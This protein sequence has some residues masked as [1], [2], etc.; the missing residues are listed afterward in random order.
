MPS[1]TPTFRALTIGICVMADVISAETI[2]APFSASYQIKPIPGSFEA[3]GVPAPYGGIAFA[4]GSLDT[5][6]MIGNAHQAGADA[7]PPGIYAI[8]V[9]RDGKGHINGFQGNGKLLAAAPGLSVS[10]SGGGHGLAGGPNG[11]LFYTS[12]DGSLG[13]IK[14]GSAA[15]DRQID[16]TTLE[17]TWIPEAMPLAFVPPGFAGGKS[18]KVVS[19]EG[20]FYAV[21]LSADGA[22]T[23]DIA[24]VSKVGVL[25]DVGLHDDGVR[26]SAT[27]LAYV[28]AGNPRFPAQTVLAID[29]D[30]N[31]GIHSDLS[32]YRIDA[33]GNPIFSSRRVMISEFGASAMTT[34]PVTGD[35]VIGGFW[36]GR[37]LVV[38]FSVPQLPTYGKPSFQVKE[39]AGGATISVKRGGSLNRPVAVNY[40]TSTGTEPGA[41]YAVPGVNYTGVQGT[42]TWAAGDNKAK[43]FTV[44]V[45]SDGGF[46]TTLRVDLNL[47]LADGGE[48]LPVSALYILNQ[49][50]KPTV[51]LTTTGQTVAEAAGTVNLTA[52]LSQPT[53]IQVIVPLVFSGTATQG[54]DYR[55]PRDENRRVIKSL[56]FP[57]NT[58]QV[59][60][61]LRLINDALP[62]PDETLIATLGKPVNADLGTLTTETITIQDND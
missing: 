31:E 4:P 25:A 28:A 26:T 36:G 6:L 45:M 33:R 50:P 60:L 48:P 49:D 29:Y 13:M 42:L 38:G 17:P 23:F 52:A 57:P 11:V 58:T 46:N 5:L 21:D 54:Q 8:K 10:T 12:P 53:P 19:A 62:E 22:G 56:V 16:L 39:T 32:A 34:D 3:P 43:S 2:Q 35:L 51:S 47:S 55:L 24:K 15:P 27:G 9:R 41:H 20:G 40:A 37:R 61:P 14:Q 44:P 7:N 1:Y 30:F 18:F 59:S